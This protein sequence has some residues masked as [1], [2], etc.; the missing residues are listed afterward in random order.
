[1]GKKIT[2]TVVFAVVAVLCVVV[3]IWIVNLLNVS[4]RYFVMCKNGTYFEPIEDIDMNL[5]YLK[6]FQKEIITYTLTIIV[7]L[8]ILII[9]TLF[10]IKMWKNDV[11]YFSKQV[12][13]NKEEFAQ[14]RKQ[15]KNRKLNE[16]IEKLKKEM[17]E[18]E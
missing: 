6:I 11:V 5:I 9:Q 18:S 10:L 1:M 15:K 16:K 7:F 14:Q 17:E 12:V 3:G 13:F 2:L 4:V 8:Y